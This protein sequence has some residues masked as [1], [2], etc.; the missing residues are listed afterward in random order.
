MVA[1]LLLAVQEAY[2]DAVERGDDRTVIAGLAAAYR[3]IRAGFGHR[4]TPAAFGAI[5]TDCYSHTPAHAGAQQPGMTGQVKEEIIARFGELGLRVIGGRLLLAP[6]LL[7]AGEVLRPDGRDEHGGS[8]QLTVCAVPV[9]IETGP[10][11]SVTMERADGTSETLDGL[12]LDAERSREIL[13]RAGTTT[14]IRWVVGADTLAAWRR[15]SSV[16]ST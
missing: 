10:R 13:A 7:P 6:G 16:A 3:R 14:Q 5:P 11:D 4:T 8:A 1:K 2:W 15:A 9:S 12:E